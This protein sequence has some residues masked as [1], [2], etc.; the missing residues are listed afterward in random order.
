MKIN[1]ISGLRR[2]TIQEHKK[3]AKYF[4]GFYAARIRTCSRL[5]VVLC[6]L[7][8]IFFSSFS[9]LGIPAIVIGALGFIWA[10]KLIRDKKAFQNWNHIFEEG[11]F[12]VLE[13]AVKEIGTNID[14]TGA[15]N[16]K[17]ISVHG[18]VLDEWYVARQ[19]YLHV[20]APLLLVYVDENMIKGGYSHVFT[21]Y[22]LTEGG[23]K[24]RL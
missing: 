21:P 17:F 16:V 13:G 3:I 20:G 24:H 7:G 23:M 1:E 11:Q 10:F 12:F 18:Q 14:R 19:E 15:D 9:T 22:M 2:P 5:S 4:D 6:V 8:V